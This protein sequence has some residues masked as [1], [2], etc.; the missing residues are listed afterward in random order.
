MRLLKL[1]I[2]GGIGLA[3]LAA[4]S[5][6]ITIQ[7]AGTTRAAERAPQSQPSSKPA[8]NIF[9][10]RVQVILKNGQK[11]SGVVKNHRYAERADGFNF[12]AT[13]KTAAEAGVR[14]WFANAGQNYLFVKYKDIDSLKTVAR[15]SDLEVRELEE[16]IYQEAKAARE[17]E[18]EE[19][20][21]ELAQ[22]AAAR[23]AEADSE[24]K[25]AEDAK[26]K[27]FEKTKKAAVTKAQILM[28]RFPP[29]QGWG[30]EKKKEIIAKKA[31]HIYPEPEETAFLKSYD[32]WVKAKAIIDAVENG[33]EPPIEADS[34]EGA[35][36][37]AKSKKGKKK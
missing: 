21:A 35:D 14:I 8:S 10:D 30:E 4:A 29:S 5:E 18:I 2:V 20:T 6:T 25:A 31:N 28:N 11:L 36:K 1:A 3:T 34:E 16:K 37:E 24:E 32:E 33:E 19:R 7:A 23:K 12:T 13:E 15:V 22:K 9:H 17:K 27:E 26:K